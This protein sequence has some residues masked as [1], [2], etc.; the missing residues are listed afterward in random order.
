MKQQAWALPF[1]LQVLADSI[2]LATARLEGR[3]LPV[4]SLTPR[5]TQ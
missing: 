4:T 2:E 3:P 1:P 5:V